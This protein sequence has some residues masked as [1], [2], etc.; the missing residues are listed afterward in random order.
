MRAAEN[1]SDTQTKA[2]LL[3]HCAIDFPRRDAARVPLFEAANDPKS[4]NYGLG[5][6]EPLFQTR[7]FRPDPSE[8][9]LE[10]EQIV[11]AGD[12]EDESSDESY[13]LGEGE[14][15]LS[16]AQRA[17]ISQL[18]ADRMARLGQFTDALS[19]YQSSRSLDTSATT[20]KVLN[21][22]IEETKLLLRIQR[23]NASRQPL[24]HEAL[25]QDRVVHPRLVA[26]ASSAPSSASKGGVKQ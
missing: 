26:H 7:Y 20:R 17:R 10:E 18:I 19:F 11:S 6:L 22:K 1:A 5:I 15:Q 16:R 14:A 4:L 21:R 2:Q 8:A 23:Q 3:S 24:L 25:E 12:D 13:V 9:G